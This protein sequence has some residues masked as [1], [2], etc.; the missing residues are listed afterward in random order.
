MLPLGITSGILDINILK[1]SD[2]NILYWDWVKVYAK[3]TQIPGENFKTRH[4]LIK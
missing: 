4:R 1:E 3:E 2:E